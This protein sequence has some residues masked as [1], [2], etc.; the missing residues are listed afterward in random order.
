LARIWGSN[1]LALALPLAY[2]ATTDATPRERKGV[3]WTLLAADSAMLVTAAAMWLGG[4]DG[5]LQAGL[6][7]QLGLAQLVPL[8][9]RAW[10]LFV[11]PDWFGEEETKGI[12]G[13]GKE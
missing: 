5:G 3:Y 13:T 6:G 12:E 10:C 4:T 7:W 11:R 1:A 2:G 8:G 9:W